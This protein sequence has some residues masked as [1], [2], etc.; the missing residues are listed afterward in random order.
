[1]NIGILERH[2]ERL[3]ARVKV[4]PWV[5]ARVAARPRLDRLA[6]DV[7]SDGLGEYLDIQ[8]DSV[9][10]DLAVVEV[11]PKERQLL[12]LARHLAAARQEKFICGH[13]EQAWFVAACPPVLLPERP[14]L[15]GKPPVAPRARTAPEVVGPTIKRN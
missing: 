15:A 10:I 6:V 11:Q 1:M 2:F 14:A 8:V 13:D 7:K 5:P 3:G 4:G 9:L 12:M